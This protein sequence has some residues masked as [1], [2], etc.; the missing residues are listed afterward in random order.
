MNCNDGKTT[1]VFA[2]RWAGRGN[3]RQDNQSFW[4]HQLSRVLGVSDTTAYI[5]SEVPV[6]LSHT[7][8]I[9]GYITTTCVLIEQNGAGIDLDKPR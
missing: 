9:D 7:S 2:A 4:I 5:R 3:E 1:G 8:C 6:M